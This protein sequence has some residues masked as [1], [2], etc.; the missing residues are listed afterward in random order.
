MLQINCYLCHAQLLHLQCWWLESNQ[1]WPLDWQAAVPHYTILTSRQLS[2][3][4]TAV[5][6]HTC[7][8]YVYIYACIHFCTTPN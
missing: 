5:Y 7:D 4:D 6:A 1:L 3:M 2:D 8:A